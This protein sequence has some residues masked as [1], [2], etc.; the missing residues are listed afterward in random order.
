MISP[1]H[2]R[3]INE[4]NYRRITLGTAYKVYASILN[5]RLEKEV[6]EKL[7]EVQFG[8]RKRNYRRNIHVELYR[9]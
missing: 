3:E 6:D 4:L 1:I 5:D 9:Q 8:F 2:K 7:K